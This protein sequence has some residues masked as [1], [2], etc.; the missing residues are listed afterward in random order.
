[1]SSVDSSSPSNKERGRLTS[2][3][4]AIKGDLSLSLAELIKNLNKEIKPHNFIFF[5][6][7]QSLK[8]EKLRLLTEINNKI[9]WLRSPAGLKELEVEAAKEAAEAVKKTEPTDTIEPNNNTNQKTKI[10]SSQLGDNVILKKAI[11]RVIDEHEHSEKINLLL[12][13]HFS[14]TRTIFAQY[15][16]VPIPRVSSCK[17]P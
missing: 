2:M 5:S 7:N 12:Q 8:K 3:E 15:G 9:I 1:M 13:G 6:P 16:L 4:E 11:D 14:R 17:A 10:T